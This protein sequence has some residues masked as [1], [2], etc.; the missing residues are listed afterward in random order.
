MFL[1]I[2]KQK[3]HYSGAFYCFSNCKAEEIQSKYQP[4]V[5]LPI[6]FKT[7]RKPNHQHKHDTDNQ[8]E[9]QREEETSKSG[10]YACQKVQ[11]RPNFAKTHKCSVEGLK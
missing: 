5:G 8:R 2:T 1:I 10:R 4:Q 3:P 7:S 9:K 11:L 6:Y